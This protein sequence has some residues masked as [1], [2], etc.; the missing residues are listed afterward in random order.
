MGGGGG[1][2]PEPVIRAFHV[3]GMYPTVRVFKGD[4]V[5]DRCT[6]VRFASLDLGA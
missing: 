2:P 3:D 6:I 1:A 5:N 4:P